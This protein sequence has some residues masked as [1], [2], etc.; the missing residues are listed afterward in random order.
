MQFRVGPYTYTLVVSDRAIFDADGNELEGVAVEGRRLIILSPIVEP[1]RRPE[2]ACHELYHAFTFAFPAPRTEEEIADF[3]GL[4]ARQFHQ[5]LH[6]QGGRQ[7]LMQMVPRRVPHLGRP[8]PARSL[9]FAR[10]VIGPG[11]RIPCG[12]CDAPVMCG[13]I[14]NGAPELHQPTGRLRMER[15]MHCE[16]C[17]SVQAWMEWCAADG[18][19]LG[20]F[21][22]NPAPKLYR[23]A[24]AGRFVAD[25]ELARA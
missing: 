15:W 5:E 18:T 7:A 4:V 1:E 10:D 20:E 16:A 2:V 22:S 14:R 8:A 6:E 23:G 17:G 21:V 9:P 13:S 3:T 24:E 12:V 11:D 25:H 19:P